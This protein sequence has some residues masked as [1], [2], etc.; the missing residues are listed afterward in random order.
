[1]TLR[2]QG[3]GERGIVNAMV[4]CVSSAGL[5]PDGYADRVRHLLDAIAWADENKPA[6][7]MQVNHASFLVEFSLG[8]F[9]NP[10]LMIVCTVPEQ[11]RPYLLFVE[12]K[13]TPYEFSAGSNIQGM[14]APG[15]NSRINGQLAL[16][17]RFAQALQQGLL[18]G[19]KDTELRESNSVYAG[20]KDGLNDPAP[21]NRRLQNQKVIRLL[22]QYGLIGL[23]EE[24]CHYVALTWDDKPERVFRADL[25]L[26]PRFFAATGDDQYSQMLSRYGWLGYEELEDRLIPRPYSEYLAARKTMM[27][28]PTP[29]TNDYARYERARKRNELSQTEDRFSTL[30]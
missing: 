22:D 2:L 7:I 18:K 13:V 10:D 26:R 12:A 28:N 4:S 25:D 11:D 3:Y 14:R 6:W 27:D 17:Y 24:R 19:D 5:N 30:R 21:T 29:G 15:F 23:P 16:K 1:M 8:E 9:G 20:Y